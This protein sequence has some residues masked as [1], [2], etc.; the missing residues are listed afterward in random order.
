MELLGVIALAF[1]LSVVTN[2][3]EKKFKIRER[4]TALVQ[5]AALDRDDPPDPLK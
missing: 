1:S 2:V 3:I 5:A 4:F